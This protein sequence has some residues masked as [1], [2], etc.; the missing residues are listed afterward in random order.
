MDEIRVIVVDDFPSQ[1]MDALIGDEQDPFCSLPYGLQWRAPEKH[2]LIKVQDDDI[3]HI[4]LVP[5]TVEVGGQR[6]SV[7]GVGGVFTR[8]DYR[9]R[10]LGVAALATAQG[11]ASREWQAQFLVL[12]C[13]PGMRGW[14]EIQ[15][16]ALIPETVWIQQ[17]DAIVSAP[18]LVMAKQLGSHAWPPGEVKLLSLPW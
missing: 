12:F 11:M 17:P 8:R 16:F 13:R 9:G 14:Y 6:L 3:C 2:V 18:L 1:R 4:G 7:A 5:H 10:G 15:G